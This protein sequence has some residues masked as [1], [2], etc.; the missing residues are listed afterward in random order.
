M[1]KGIS[2]CE[3]CDG[4]LYKNKKIAIIGK[5]PYLQKAYD[6]LLNITDEIIVFSEDEGLDYSH[7]IGEKNYV[8]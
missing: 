1:G 5:N 8:F 7:L 6:Y 4:F 2:L 3:V